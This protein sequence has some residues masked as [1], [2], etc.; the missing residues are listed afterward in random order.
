M[1][2]IPI[3]KFIISAQQRSQ[4]VKNATG[5]IEDWESLLDVNTIEL[6][7]QNHSAFFSFLAFDASVDKD[8]FEYI[9]TGALAGESGEEF[10]VLYII[11]KILNSPTLVKENDLFDFMEVRTER[12]LNKEI[13]K[14]FFD[15][16]INITIPGL[17][18]FD[19]IAFS[20]KTLF[21]PFIGQNNYT[22]LDC[23]R[24]VVSIMAI[25]ETKL[26]GKED[27]II[28]KISIQLLL[29]NIE[30]SKNSS[31][32]FGEFLIKAFKILKEVK[33]DLIAIFV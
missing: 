10:M 18:I 22:K 7:R 30:Y 3:S 5:L 26:R 15:S 4:K 20:K 13:V 6:L 17:L 1:N 12:N 21:V 32:T 31:Y 16:K 29:S 14:S 8:I 25:A 23:F 24:K 27:S 11:N 33:S 2:I 9:E 19:N 28:D